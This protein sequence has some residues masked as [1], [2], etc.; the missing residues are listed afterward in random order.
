MIQVDEPFLREI[1]SS[2]QVTEQIINYMKAHD[3]IFDNGL[4]P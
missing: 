4:G 2:D 3:I 1:F